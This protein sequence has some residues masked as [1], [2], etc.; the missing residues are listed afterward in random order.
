MNIPS[1]RVRK[2]SSPKAAPGRFCWPDWSSSEYFELQ[3]FRHEPED[4]LPL[5]ERTQIAA[6]WDEGNLYLE[7]KIFDQEVWATYTTHDARLFHEE[8][9]EFFVDPDG[10]G[11]RYIEA[12]VNSLGTVRDLLVDGTIPHPTLAQFDMMAHWHFRAIRN[13]VSELKVDGDRVAGWKLQV[14]IPWDEF[15]FGRRTW[16]PQPGEEL[17]IN[18][19]RYERP[20]SGAGSLEL[21][22]WSWVDSTFHQPDRF[23]RLIFESG[24]GDSTRD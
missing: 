20:R 6:L 3:R 19:Y 8:C 24:D 1:Y 11:R 23:G 13:E 2:I 10:D 18:F 17:R 5:R 12:Q 21:S 14:A 15:D 7:F 9:V 16:P 22:G 4:D